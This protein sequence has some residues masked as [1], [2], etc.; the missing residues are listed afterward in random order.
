MKN[1]VQYS[2]GKDSTATLQYV[3]SLNLK[4]IEV[5]FCDTGWEAEETYEYL[6]YIK[7]KFK[8]CKFITLTSLKYNGFEDLSLKK[9]RVAST[10][11]RF[12]TEELKVKPFIDWILKQESNFIIY[13]GIRKNESASRST[14]SQQCTFFKYYFEPKRDKNGNIIL[15]KK[16]KPKFDN[17]R[18][19]DVLKWC[20]KYNADIERPIFDWTA[21]DVFDYH[22]ENGIKINPL[23]MKG[24]TRVGCYP[25]IMCRHREITQIVKHSPERIDKIRSLEDKLQRSF[26]PPKYIPKWACK[27]GKF[28]MVDEVV[29]YL[30][31]DPNQETF[32]EE[33][34]TCE[35]VYNICE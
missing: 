5:V 15:D 14:M 31:D 17:Y 16:G 7:K 30:Q 18:K 28:P 23:Y 8:Q 26:F 21:K 9:K 13:Q 25:C 12:C 33:Y 22:I 27:N 29:R 2:G 6:E 19:K 34:P 35:S 4:T 1:I 32:I 10:K 24:M 3:C 11:A 20:E